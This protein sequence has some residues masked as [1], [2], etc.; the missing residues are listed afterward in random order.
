MKPQF[1][2]LGMVIVGYNP[3]TKEGWPGDCELKSSLGYVLCS[4]QPELARTILKT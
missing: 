1:L 4:G 2:T 3:S